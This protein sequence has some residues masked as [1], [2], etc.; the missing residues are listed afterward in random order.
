M[1]W[2][3]LSASNESVTVT[4]AELKSMALTGRLHPETLVWNETLPDW[5]PARDFWA[6]LT[7]EP[8]PGSVS[9]PPPPA[10]AQARSAQPPV[11][12]PP[13]VAGGVA[14]KKSGCGRILGILALIGLLSW[15]G[16]LVLRPREP[17]V[18]KSPAQIAYEQANSLIGSSRAESGS[19]STPEE[20]SAA[21]IMAAG[22]AAFR[23]MT[24]EKGSG[25]SRGIFQNVAKAADAKG[26]TAYC[27]RKGDEVLFLLHVP[28]LRK[29][30]D[31]AKEQMAENA[32]AAALQAVSTMPDPKPKK[33]AVA[34]R[35]ILSYDRL[36]KGNVIEEFTE[37]MDSENL[38]ARRKAFGIATVSTD[39]STMDF[40]F[41]DF[42]REPVA[43][44]PAATSPKP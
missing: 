7:G 28:D 22:A 13:F 6:Q 20:K 8:A 19:G 23:E 26:F 34:T 40:C 43:G 41:I 18:P 9:A 25:R 36:I 4:Q 44:K 5:K 29:F 30:T 15:I 27:K 31:G 42:F 37:E 11:F 38:A 32:W 10:P 24:I 16:F 39:S 1:N 3:Y 35:G 17:E 2:N 33:M 14:P 12:R 21:K